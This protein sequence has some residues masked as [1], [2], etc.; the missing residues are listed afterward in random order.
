M[1]GWKLESKPWAGGHGLSGCR[2]GKDC[3]NTQYFRKFSQ[4]FRKSESTD[5][6]S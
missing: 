3:E 1:P 2:G 5:C 6:F 4:Y